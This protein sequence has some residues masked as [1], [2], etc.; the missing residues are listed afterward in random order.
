MNRPMYESKVDLTHETKMKTFLETKWNCTLN[1]LPLKYQLD[2]MAMRGRDPMGFVEFKH[3]EKLS[4]DAYPRYMI[5]LDKWMKAKQLCKEVEIP[6]IMVITFTEGTY[7]GVFAHNGLHDVT[8]GFGGRYDRG[9]AQDVEPM[10]Y[11]PLKKF[12][13]IEGPTL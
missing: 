5:S 2:W 6:F 10:I 11:L 13:K 4:I 7:Y 3:R 9:D 1:K 12:Q 8:Y